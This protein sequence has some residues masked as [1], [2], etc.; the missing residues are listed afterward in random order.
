[1]ATQKQIKKT[2]NTGSETGSGGIRPATVAG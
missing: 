1:M 2:G